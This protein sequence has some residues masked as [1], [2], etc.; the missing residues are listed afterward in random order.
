M[1]FADPG[2]S[3][4]FGHRHACGSRQISSQDVPTAHQMTVALTRTIARY[5]I[6]GAPKVAH[7]LAAEADDA[8]I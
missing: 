2:Y 6:S 8:L 3:S 5:Q 7:W 4:V 1:D